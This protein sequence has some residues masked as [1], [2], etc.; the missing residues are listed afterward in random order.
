[1]FR[2]YMDLMKGRIKN[3]N[4]PVIVTYDGKKA[5]PGKIIQYEPRDFT[6]LDE[7]YWDEIDVNK[8]LRR[9]FKIV[10]A[11]SIYVDLNLVWT[12]TPYN[13]IY[14]YKT[15]N[16]I[17][18]YRPMSESKTGKWISNC[19]KFDVQGWEQLPDFP[20]CGTLI[21]TKSL[22]DVAVLRSLGYLAIAPSSE[23]TMIPPEAMK[24]LVS[25]F[26][27]KKFI[28]IYDRDHGGMIGAR[29]M[30]VKYRGEYDIIFKFIG[31]GFPKDVSAFRRQYGAHTLKR[32]LLNL[33]QYV[34]NE[35]F[36][37]L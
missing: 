29:K 17:R 35:K 36:A 3:P 11:N 20:D 37:I 19:T 10:G 31:R 28:I 24:L 27:F 13:P 8:N 12:H 25:K 2:V 22:K 14:V 4:S 32:Y 15:F 1:M 34:P 33:L 6:D 16:K 30:F 23:N 5:I 21:I 7:L 26:G 18:A 9:L